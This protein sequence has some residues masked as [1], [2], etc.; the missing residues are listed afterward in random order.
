MLI[1]VVNSYG[2]KC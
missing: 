2:R 1:T